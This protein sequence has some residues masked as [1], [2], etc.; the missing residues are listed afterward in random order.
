MSLTTLLLIAAAAAAPA[1]STVSGAD[2]IHVP[3]AISE[4]VIVDE[5]EAQAR[6]RG[7][8]SSRSSPHE[9]GLGASLMAGNH[10]V[11][12]AF[13]Y[14]FGDM[15]GVDFL[16]SWF[17]VQAGRGG[18]SQGSIT[19]ISPSVMVMLTPPDS[20]R[21]IDVRPFVGGGVDVGPKLGD[22]GDRCADDRHRRPGLRR[23]RDDVRRGAVGGD[24]CSGDV[25]RPANQCVT[26][27]VF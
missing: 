16:A 21:S 24:Q 2:R 18:Q 13:R 20:S 14:W 17:N 26:R 8:P 7:G 27:H 15:V 3:M 5:T 12:G 22:D 1:Q 9:F 11:G 10:G 19:Q 6:P 25:H 4:S 23:H